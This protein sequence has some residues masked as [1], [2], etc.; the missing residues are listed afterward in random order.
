MQYY[1]A[2]FL[3]GQTKGHTDMRVWGIKHCCCSLLISTSPDA[4]ASFLI[5]RFEKIKTSND[6]VNESKRPSNVENMQIVFH[7]WFY[8][9]NIQE[10]EIRL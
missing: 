5:P 8:P 4:V 9:L 10:I 2:S 3:Q 7:Y 1:T 6:F